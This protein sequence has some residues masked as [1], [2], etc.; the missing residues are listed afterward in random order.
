VQPD[1][2]NPG[3]FVVHCAPRRSHQQVVLR[4][5]L[6]R[7]RRSLRPA[8]PRHLVV[9]ADLVRARF[10]LHPAVPRPDTPEV[11]DPDLGELPPRVPEADPLRPRDPENEGPGN[12]IVGYRDRRLLDVSAWKNHRFD[13]LDFIGKWNSD[14]AGNS[15]FVKHF[16]FHFNERQITVR[17]PFTLV[18]EMK[19]FWTNRV[20]D[21]AWE[22]YQLSVARC[23]I[24]VS[25]L[26]ITAEEQ[27][28]ANLYAP[29]VGFAESWDKQQNVSRVVQ[30]AHFDM[31]LYSWP[32]L[33]SSLRTGFGA[34]FVAAVCV[35]VV[36]VTLE[37]VTAV[38]KARGVRAPVP[39]E[40]AYRR[41]G[42]SRF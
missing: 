23:R 24:I 14:R 9:P 2:E 39:Q 25:E 20:R 4:R 8:F 29:A 3:V 12:H 6:L 27:Y 36:I 28:V 1:P 11:E 42:E 7:M 31:R 10:S 22:N 33:K 37:L 19:D 32:K 38:V 30:G 16:G 35:A 21:D 41:G 26:A 15:T 13:H 18:A 34:T 17:L 5:E 40:R